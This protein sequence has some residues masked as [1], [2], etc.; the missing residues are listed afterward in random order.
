[1]SQTFSFCYTTLEVFSLKSES[2]RP[3]YL[4]YFVMVLIIYNQLFPKRI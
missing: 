2:F 3:F 1:M 4:K